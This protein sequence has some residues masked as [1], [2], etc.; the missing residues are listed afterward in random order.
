MRPDAAELEQWI[1]A[2]EQESR[3]LTEANKARKR[4]VGEV[5]NCCPK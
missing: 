4:D 3:R 5:L 1:K 2:L